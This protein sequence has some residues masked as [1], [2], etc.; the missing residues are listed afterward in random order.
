M[1]VEMTKKYWEDH[2]DKSCKGS[3]VGKALEAYVLNCPRSADQIK[4]KEHFEKAFETLEA[5]ESALKVGK[6]KTS[7]IKNAE[8]K[9]GTVE[10]IDEM[11]KKRKKYKEGLEKI[12]D[13]FKKKRD[14]A[15]N[16]PQYQQKI[17]TYVDRR[18]KLLEFITAGHKETQAFIAR[19]KTNNANIEKLNT[20]LDVAV[21][22]KKDMEMAKTFL[23][24]M[25][26]LV[27][28]SMDLGDKIQTRYDKDAPFIKQERGPAADAKN[29]GV[30]PEDAKK[31]DAL[32]SKATALAAETG[33]LLRESKELIKD[34]VATLTDAKQLVVNGGRTLDSALSM[35]NNLVLRITEIQSNINSSKQK[36]THSAQGVIT[37]AA[38]KMELG[39]ADLEIKQNSATT[40]FNNVTNESSSLLSLVGQMLKTLQEGQAK[41]PKELLK[42]PT[43][44]SDAE[45]IKTI[46]T[47]VVK[48]KKEVETMLAKA[49]KD[50]ATIMNR[51]ATKD[52]LG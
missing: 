2:R 16:D 3:G 41:I 24:G 49:R 30:L 18:Q 35:S 12:F 40:Q 29:M 4:K 15:G 38:E 22:K 43:I 20:N 50:Y 14:D 45:K 9:K 11:E 37:T 21:S 26:T 17:K 19:I 47:D 28:Q 46:V 32:F 1:A 5:L 44:K 51:K 25:E 33:D 23:K 31:H 13:E 7:G 52:R 27:Q 34:I 39:E 6:G 10:M 36:F 42:D 8:S 48:T